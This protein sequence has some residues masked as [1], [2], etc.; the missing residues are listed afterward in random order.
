[1][2]IDDNE[3]LI[4][5]FLNFDPSLLTSGSNDEFIFPD[6]QK[7]RG[8]FE[9]S[10]FEIGTLAIGGSALGGMRGLI[11][12]MRDPEVKRLPNPAIRQTQILNC[13]TKSG[14]SIG[15]IGGSIGLVYAISDFL[16]QK[17]RGDH[18]DDNINTFAATTTTGLLYTLPGL[19]S[20]NGLIRLVKGGFIGAASHFMVPT[21]GCEACQSTTHH[22]LDVIELAHYK[23]VDYPHSTLLCFS[24]SRDRLI[25]Y[26]LLLKSGFKPFHNEPEPVLDIDLSDFELRIVEKLVCPFAPTERIEPVNPNACIDIG[27]ISAVLE[28]KYRCCRPHFVPWW[29]I[30]I[31]KSVHLNK[32]VR[33]LNDKLPIHEQYHHLKRISA[34][35][36]D[37]KMVS[38]H[39]RCATFNNEDETRSLL[40]QILEPLEISYDLSTYWLPLHGPLTRRQQVALSALVA[41]PTTLHP[42]VDLESLAEHSLTCSYFTA[43]ESKAI[44]GWMNVSDG[45]IDWVKTSTCCLSDCKQG[46]HV[47]AVDDR[48]EILAAVKCFSNTDATKPFS[49]PIMKMLQICG[50]SKRNYSHLLT[51]C[52]VYLSSEPCTM[53]SMALLHSRVAR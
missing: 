52:D 43:E 7:K 8:R 6:G 26:N 40:D 51:G 34:V 38:I 47:L 4:S 24:S 1:M 16:I 45:Q 53:C 10:F 19:R 12:G 41:W 17:M 2:T 29:I 20:P 23:T 50:Q 33:D 28:P 37:P 46:M 30:R 11:T 18:A 27:K 21:G 39:V 15:Q 42:N 31:S 22:L 36:L 5:P 44:N 35:K 9:R 13:V 14:A 25:F 3:V 32:I 49:H 48:G